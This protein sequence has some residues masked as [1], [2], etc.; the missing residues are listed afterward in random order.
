MWSCETGL[1][2]GVKYAAQTSLQ[3]SAGPCENTIRAPI[4]RNICPREFS[5]KEIIRRG[6]EQAHCVDCSAYGVTRPLTCLR[7][8]SLCV[9]RT[10]CGFIACSLRRSRLLDANVFCPPYC[11]F[12]DW[13]G[14]TGKETGIAQCCSLVHLLCLDVDCVFFFRFENLDNRVVLEKHQDMNVF[15]LSRLFLAARTNVDKVQTLDQYTYIIYFN[16]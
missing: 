7:F 1:A 5:K 4:S 6:N 11:L 16:V 9:S 12:T 15:L 8:N 10:P 3:G 13:E 2:H 14:S